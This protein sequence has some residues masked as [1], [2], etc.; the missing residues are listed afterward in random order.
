MLEH[1]EPVNAHAQL[2]AEA[3]AAFKRI[4][5]KGQRLD[6]PLWRRDYSS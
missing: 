3:V 5:R 2:V 4:M 1:G 6:S